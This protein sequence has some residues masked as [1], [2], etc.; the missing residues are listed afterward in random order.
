MSTTESK[1]FF[2]YYDITDPTPYETDTTIFPGEQCALCEKPFYKGDEI[3]MLSHRT[4][5]HDRF[6]IHRQCLAERM[7]GLKLDFYAALDVLDELGFDV[8]EWEED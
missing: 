2:E 3:L 7:G 5:G 6:W 8:E 1:S 4:V